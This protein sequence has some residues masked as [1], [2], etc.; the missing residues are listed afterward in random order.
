MIKRIVLYLIKKLFQVEGV[1]SAIQRQLDLN[2]TNNNN[3]ACLIYG[4]ET[5]LHSDAIILNGTNKKENISLGDN[6]L[7]RG[8]L[9]TFNYGGIISIGNH[10]YI[11]D[12]V[13]I[14]SA[15]KI[16]IGNDVLISHN[17]NIIDTDSH[18][19]NSIERKENGRKILK[20]GLILP[21]GNVKSAPIIIEDNVWLSFNVSV[22]KGVTIGKGAVVAAGSV[23]TKNVASY[24][25]VGGTPAKFIK[26]LC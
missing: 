14:W 16:S 18:E 25:L 6:C 1:A 9:L 13:R 26:K 15:E 23:V 3:N 20:D 4:K 11:G 22:L 8:T 21:K 12:L 19:L 7:C 5:V 24:T 2:K 10:C 17:V